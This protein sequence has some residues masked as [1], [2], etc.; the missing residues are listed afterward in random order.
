MSV[1]TLAL[2]NAACSFCP[3]PTLERKGVKMPDTVIELLIA[4]MATFKVPFV[5]SPFKVN[6]PFLDC[7]LQD[8]CESF[9]SRCRN[10][11]LRL[12]TNGSALTPDHLRWVADLSRVKH[13]W[14]SLNTVDPR[15]HQKL[16]RFKRGGEDKSSMFS[17]IARHL[18]VLHGWVEKGRFGHE[19]VLSRV[20]QGDTQ[21][22]QFMTGCRARWPRFKPFLIK[23]DAWLGAV[24]APA[25]EVP[26]APCARWYELSILATGIASLCCMDGEGRFA[27][28]EVP[29]Q[30]LLEVYNAPRWRGYR[31]TLADRHQAPICQTC[32]Y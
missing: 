31:E 30:S 21:D 32:T 9:L 18:D 23:K 3:Y 1:E 29:R 16:M 15:E 27:I 7:R 10:G 12:F 17:K 14:V 20:A 2:C 5:F 28:G 4:E 13:L 25:V 22:F 6:E 26:H 24:K 19:V 11:V 8:I